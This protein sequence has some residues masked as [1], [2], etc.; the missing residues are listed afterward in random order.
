MRDADDILGTK[1]ENSIKVIS[2][3]E[4]YCEFETVLREMFATRVIWAAVRSSYRYPAMIYS[5]EVATA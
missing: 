1:V 5:A 2:L 3:C 4:P